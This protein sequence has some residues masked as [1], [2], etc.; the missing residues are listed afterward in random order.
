MEESSCRWFQQTREAGGL[1]GP[2]TQFDG[3]RDEFPGDYSGW[4]IFER[5]FRNGGDIL[6]ILL[7]AARSARRTV[8]QA[9]LTAT[10]RAA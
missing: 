5:L 8:F 7:C 1:T 6:A 9:R 2:I 10:A 3:Y 4:R